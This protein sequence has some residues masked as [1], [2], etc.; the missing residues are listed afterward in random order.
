MLTRLVASRALQRQLHGGRIA[1]EDV[2]H[3]VVPGGAGAAVQRVGPL[4]GAQ[5]V[6]LA[7]QA[8]LGAGDAVGHTADHAAEVRTVV[9][10]HKQEA[11]F[12]GRF[13]G[14]STLLY[15]SY[16]SACAFYQTVQ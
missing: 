15:V 3:A 4:V 6:L 8:E 2:P 16:N 1:R 14:F 11:T 7:V 10:L 5:D 9:V 13:R 12:R